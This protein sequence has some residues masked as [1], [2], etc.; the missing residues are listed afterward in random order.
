MK[1]VMMGMGALLPVALVGILMWLWPA[2]AVEAQASVPCYMEQGGRRWVAGGGCEWEMQA[3]AMFDVQAGVTSNFGGDLSV[4]DDLTVL[5]D[6]IVGANLFTARATQAVTMNGWIT[7]TAA[8]MQLSAAGT[9]N[10]SRILTGTAG[11]RLTLLNG[12]NQSIVLSD[13]GWLK[14]SGN[15]T[16]G[17][18]DTLELVSDGS[19]WVQVATSNN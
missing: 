10:T 2:P 5:G 3:G 16:L 6:V 11:Q 15:I 12:V 14:L 8:L 19:N 13:T 4:A 17:Q 9:V 1:R 7:P 18:Y